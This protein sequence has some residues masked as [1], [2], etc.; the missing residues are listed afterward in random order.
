MNSFTQKAPREYSALH[1]SGIMLGDGY[2]EMNKTVCSLFLGGA[3]SLVGQTNINGYTVQCDKNLPEANE[4]RAL[5]T[6][7]KVLMR[8]RISYP[9]YKYHSVLCYT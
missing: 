7:R 1:A 8:S 2:T 6:E 9:R 3:H 4:C 5:V